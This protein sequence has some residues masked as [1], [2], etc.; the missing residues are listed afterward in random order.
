MKY[1]MLTIV[2]LA[3]FRLGG[4]SLETYLKLAVENNPMLRARHAAME[5]P[6]QRGIQAGSLPDPQVSLE[7]FPSPMM[8]PMGNQ[9][10]SLS[11]M[12]MFPL[13]GTLEANKNVA[14]AEANV[15]Y[16]AFRIAK[17]E[18]IFKVKSAWYP[19]YELKQTIRI[20]KE[21]IRLLETDKELAVFKFS[22]GLG[23][24][25]DAIRT[26]LMIDEAK[27]KIALLEQKQKVLEAVF[28]LLLNRPPDD[29]VV[30]A[31][32]LKMGVLSPD[33]LMDSLRFN[34]EL[35]AWNENIQVAKAGVIAAQKQALPGFTA[36]VAYTPLVRRNEEIHLLPNTG[37]DMVMGMV[38]VS[39]PIWKKKNQA[40]V[41]ENRVMQL[42][43]EAERQNAEN[44][45][46]AEYFETRFE[47]EEAIQ[48]DQLLDTRILK[49]Q[50]AVDLL[51][52]AYGNNGENFE[53]ILEMRRNLLELRISKIEM[54]TRF[55][56]GKAK[57]AFLTGMG[58]EFD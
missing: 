42:M 32:T 39:L 57:L 28:N 26:D 45:L 47:L 6:M 10:A 22:H 44:E 37:S 12:Q 25:V 14:I 3:G 15:K 4:Q 49:T 13:F 20:Q 38:G 33:Y 31:D 35:A 41:E 46:L 1:L 50:Q 53:E 5:A 16:Q 43:Y 27:T 2:L 24:M 54:V 55:Y 7:F 9:V 30:A 29:P 48:M 58:L 34:P 40:M 21:N 17:N 52:A 11:V 51:V 23:S 18:L 8:L 19:L 36:G 56:M